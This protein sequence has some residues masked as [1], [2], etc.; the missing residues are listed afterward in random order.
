[1]K[2]KL[3]VKVIELAKEFGDLKEGL[4]TYECYDLAIKAIQ[5]DYEIKVKKKPKK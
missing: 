2:R 4:S 3:K 5:L 1:M